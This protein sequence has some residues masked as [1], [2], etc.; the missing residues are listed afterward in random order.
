MLDPVTKY[1]LVMNG[2]LGTLVGLELMTDGF[3]Q[4]NQKV[5]NRGEIYV[6][7]TPEHHAC[8]SDRGGVRS[9]PTTGADTG[10]T[11]RGW[12]MSELLS[13]TMANPRSVSKGRRV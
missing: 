7:S 6:V 5:L 8:Y 12:L 11:S 9:E 10:S 1:D 2:N 4:P 13:F 3:R